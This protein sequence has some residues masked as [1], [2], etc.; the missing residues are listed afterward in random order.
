[1]INFHYHIDFLESQGIFIAMVY[2]NSDLLAASEPFYTEKE[3]LSW[4]SGCII[5]I[6]LARGEA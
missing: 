4:A 3:T 2:G 6:K 5:G 1:M